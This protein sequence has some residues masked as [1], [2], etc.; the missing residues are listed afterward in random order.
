MV[1]EE[2]AVFKNE[3][4]TPEE[5]VELNSTPGSAGALSATASPTL[6]ER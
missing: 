3:G 1:V 4:D 2:M 6:V 5:K